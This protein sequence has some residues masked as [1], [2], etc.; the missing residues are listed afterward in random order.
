MPFTMGYFH[1]FHYIT[2]YYDAHWI[3]RRE[4]KEFRL[5]HC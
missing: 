3:L 5:G 1:R 4:I 2:D